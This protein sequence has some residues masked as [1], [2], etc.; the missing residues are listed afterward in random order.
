[1]L[2]FTIIRTPYENEY[3]LVTYRQTTKQHRLFNDFV[4]FFLWAHLLSLH[5]CSSKCESC[6]RHHCALGTNSCAIS[7]LRTVWILYIYRDH[8]WPIFD[9]FPSKHSNTTRVF[10]DTLTHWNYSFVWNR[11]VFFFG[12]RVLGIFFSFRVKVSFELVSMNFSVE[13]HVSSN[14]AFQKLYLFTNHQVEDRE[15]ETTVKRD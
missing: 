6:W 7:Q 4:L 8:S 14:E 5:I 15:R 9:G 3:G 1:M 12:G 13:V 2:V 10:S 11:K